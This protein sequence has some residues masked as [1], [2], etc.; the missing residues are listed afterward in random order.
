[1]LN[2][3]KENKMNKIDRRQAMKATIGAAAALAASQTDVSASQSREPKKE[4]SGY[5]HSSVLTIEPIL[6]WSGNGGV[7]K[8]ESPAETWDI[9]G[10]LVKVENQRIVHPETLE[11]CL[12]LSPV[13]L[14]YRIKVER[15]SGIIK[16]MPALLAEGQHVEVLILSSNTL[17]WI[18]T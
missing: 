1:M 16:E 17:V 5:T 4:F 15:T 8:E 7:E 11:P 14:I 2:K 6:T 9:Y 18:T 3:T 12:P 10:R 13:T